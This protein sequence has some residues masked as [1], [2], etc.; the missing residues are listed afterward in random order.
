MRYFSTHWRGNNAILFYPLEVQ[1]PQ[2]R[3]ESYMYQNQKNCL[4]YLAEKQSSIRSSIFPQ[5]LPSEAPMSVDAGL[6]V[7]NLHPCVT[8]ARRS[9][10]IW[11][12]G[13]SPARH[14]NVL[15]GDLC[16]GSHWWDS[17]VKVSSPIDYLCAVPYV[18]PASTAFFFALQSNHI[19][20]ISSQS[21]QKYRWLF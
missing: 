1:L 7:A 21:A 11:T 9:D 8:T 17:N 18:Q 5:S 20:H 12:C 10:H 13:T 16:C 14:S 2:H 15:L 4:A 19:F 3:A 6:S